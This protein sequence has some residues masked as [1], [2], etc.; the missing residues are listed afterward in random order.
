MSY[1]LEALRKSEQERN[2][3]ATPD[4]TTLHEGPPEQLVTGPRPS[5]LPWFVGGAL[6]LNAIVLA[7]W[8]LRPAEEAPAAAVVGAPAPARALHHGAVHQPPRG[9]AA[10]TPAPPR[11]Q[12][13]RRSG[14]ASLA[15][16]Q[17]GAHTALGPL[18]PLPPP[19]P[20]PLPS[21][22]VGR[23]AEAKGC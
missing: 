8:L 21:P 1:I 4:I 11:P 13:A 23:A 7:A 9:G 14:D 16:K 5:R 10:P 19:P 20:P 17:F 6:I 3:G 15:N 22:V 12:P 2:R 18:T